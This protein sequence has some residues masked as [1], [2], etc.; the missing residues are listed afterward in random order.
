VEAR[1]GPS[2]GG[3]ASSRS[4]GGI[5]FRTAVRDGRLIG[6]NVG[7]LVVETLLRP[8]HHDVDFEQ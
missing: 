7:R 2:A 6:D 1:G 3:C 8:F 5:H 4:Y